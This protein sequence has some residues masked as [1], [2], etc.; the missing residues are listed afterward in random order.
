MRKANAKNF[1]ADR[2]NGKIKEH[3]GLGIESRLSPEGEI[4]T[5]AFLKTAFF[6]GI[7]LTQKDIESP[8]IPCAPEGMESWYNVGTKGIVPTSD[9]ICAVAHK[10]MV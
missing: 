7:M 6:D 1:S 4:S 10:V 5:S 3:S 2:I 9:S 8:L